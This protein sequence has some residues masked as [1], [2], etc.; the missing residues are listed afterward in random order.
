M[1]LFVAAGGLSAAEEAPKAIPG[2]MPE[3]PRFATAD[4]HWAHLE[5]LQSAGPKRAPSREEQ[6]KL[7][8]EWFGAQA[9]SAAAFVTTYKDDPRMWNAVVIALRSNLQLRQIAGEQPRKE[10]H[11]AVE[12]IL[13]SPEP[14]A[15]VKGE[16]AFVAVMLRTELFDPN[17]PASFRPFHNA[18]K[19]YLRTYPTHPLAGE[20]REAQF[21]ILHSYDTPE[22]ETLLKE[23]A[24]S[25]DAATAGAAQELLAKRARLA[26]LKAKPLELKFT[27]AD[28]SEV[29]LAK[30]RGKVV[31]LDFWAT[32]CPPCIAEMPNVVS[33]YEKLREKGFE[34]IGV[35]LDEDKAQM[36]ATMKK[37]K[38][39]WPQYFDGAVWK[40]KITQDFGISSLPE[41][42][43]LDRKGMIRDTGLRGENLGAA[44]EKL[45]AE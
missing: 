9:T 11:E 30:L 4:E 14:S 31:L 8:M 24:S 19:D 35:S 32:W 20:V 16:A 34:V 38:M 36:E 12:A 1:L 28:G 3:A 42:W 13:A 37:F 6:L 2:E 40:N 44:V 25:T 33:T 39:T 23:L 29:D 17:D 5:K 10:D 21:Q 22:H 41:T 18:V 7:L 43:L 27:A 15:E 45:L 26:E